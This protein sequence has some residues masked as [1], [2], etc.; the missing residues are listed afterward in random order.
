[1]NG[2]W[3]TAV[4][5][6][7]DESQVVPRRNDQK[8]C[9]CEA[10]SRHEGRREQEQV[11][12]FEARS[13]PQWSW[14]GKYNRPCCAAL[15]DIV[16]DRQ[17]FAL[18]WRCASPQY[19]KTALFRASERGHVDIVRLLLDRGASVDAADY[20]SQPTHLAA[21]PS[22][23]HAASGPMPQ[24]IECGWARWPAV[25]VVVAARLSVR[26]VDEHEDASVRGDHT[27][28]QRGLT[29]LMMA[30]CKDNLDI[31]RLLLDEGANVDATSVVSHRSAP[32][33]AE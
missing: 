32:R 6:V 3:P 5:A 13:P 4:S 7:R 8:S 15:A 17:R 22:S 12:M 20:V 33:N 30:A 26:L 25:W 19:G 2:M 1:M 31:V 27:A 9:C 16:I 28:S 11:H 29:A 18:G 14:P 24:R 21:P 10:W 23:L